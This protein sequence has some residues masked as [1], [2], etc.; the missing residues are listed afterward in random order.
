MLIRNIGTQIV[1]DTSRW[2]QTVRD[3]SVLQLNPKANFK[4]FGSV[5]INYAISLIDVFNLVLC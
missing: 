2:D 4:I 5:V 3:K 1:R